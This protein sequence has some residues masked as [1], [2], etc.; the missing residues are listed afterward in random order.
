MSV[1]LALGKQKQKGQE[2]KVI[3]RCTMSSRPALATGSSVSKANKQKPFACV[4]YVCVCVFI[5]QFLEEKSN[6]DT[7]HEA[8]H[9]LS[10]LST[11]N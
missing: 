9:S 10:H 1:L 7:F 5:C 3:L 2:F 4:L 8:N 11:S 6:L